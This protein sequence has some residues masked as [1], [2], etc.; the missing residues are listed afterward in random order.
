MDLSAAKLWPVMADLYLHLA[1]ICQQ[2][3][4]LWSDFCQ[5]L[6]KTFFSSFLHVEFLACR[7]LHR[8]IWSLSLVWNRRQGLRF[9]SQFSIRSC[10]RIAK[11]CFK[12]NLNIFM[13]DL[14]S[15]ILHVIMVLMGTYFRKTTTGTIWES[16]S[17]YIAYAKHWE[18]IHSA[19]VN[20]VGKCS[21]EPI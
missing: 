11:K 21:R 17:G 15:G 9:L 18:N 1:F 10:L 13:N 2:D 5:I 12:K 19:L 20:K 16:C 3:R 14:V 8:L 6:R 4:K 7:Q